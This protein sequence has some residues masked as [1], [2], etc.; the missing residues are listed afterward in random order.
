VHP[1]P[2]SPQE[3]LLVGAY[4]GETR[5]WTTSLI[6]QPSREGALFYRSTQHLPHF[7]RMEHAAAGIG[8][9]F[10]FITGGRKGTPDQPVISEE[11][12]APLPDQFF[13]FPLNGSLPQLPRWDHTATNITNT[14]ILII[15]GFNTAGQAIRGSEW[16]EVQ[17]N[18]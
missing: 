17:S 5:T 15:G 16:F 13:Y 4:F 3:H 14:R 9:S 11:I 10:V 1:I 12:Y 7:P 18:N 8:A 6:L 2:G